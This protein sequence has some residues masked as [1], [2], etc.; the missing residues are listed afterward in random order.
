MIGIG[1]LGDSLDLGYA[2]NYLGPAQLPSFL[3][4]CSC[5]EID[6]EL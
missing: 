3:G 6:E 1:V 4:A 2:F 5:P